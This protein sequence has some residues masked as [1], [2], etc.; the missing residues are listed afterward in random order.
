MSVWR[1]C[2]LTAEMLAH[3]FAYETDYSH[4]AVMFAIF[5]M[6]Y[7]WRSPQLVQTFT[8]VGFSLVVPTTMAST[9]CADTRKPPVFLKHGLDPHL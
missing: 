9:F 8:V 6:G 3:V 7:V 4:F 5:W 2:Q 1:S